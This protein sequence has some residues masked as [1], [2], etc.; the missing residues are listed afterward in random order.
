MHAAD[1]GGQDVGVLR[2]VVVAGAVHVGG[3][4]GDEVGAVL[5][6]VGIAKTDAGESIKYSG[7]LKL[8]NSLNFVPLFPSTYQK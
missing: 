4:G 6:V 2:V 7:Q 5:A 3:H 8:P 1:E